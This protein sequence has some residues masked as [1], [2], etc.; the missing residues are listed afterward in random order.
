[1]LEAARADRSVAAALPAGADCPGKGRASGGSVGRGAAGAGAGA[2]SARAADSVA[3]ASAALLA[4][5]VRFFT[6]S[7]S[8]PSDLDG[9]AVDGDLGMCWESLGQE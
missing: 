7:L 6:G 1:M 2:G 3:G 8:D 9:A 4:V 5:R